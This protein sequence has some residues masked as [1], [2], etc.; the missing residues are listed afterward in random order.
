MLTKILTPPWLWVLL[1]WTRHLGG[2]APPYQFFNFTWQIINEAGDIANSSSTIA[3]TPDWGPLE[4]DLCKLALGGH[5]D[6]GVHDKFL[7]LAKAP[8]IP[9]DFSKEPGC[10]TRFSRR[11][12][13]LIPIYVCPGASHRDRSLAYKC[14]FSPDYFCAS[15]GCETTGDTYWN[16]SSSWDYIQVKRKGP[17][18]SIAARCTPHRW[19]NPLVIT[20]TEAGKRFDWASSRGLEWGLRLYRSG[21]DF[22]VTFKIKLLKTV[23]QFAVTAVGPNKA[24]HFLT[25]EQ[26]SHPSTH[27]QTPTNSFSVSAPPFQPTLPQGPPSSADLILSMV[28][29][30]IDALHAINDSL[31]EECWVCFSPKPP[32][33]EGVAAFGYPNLTNDTRH[34]GWHPVDDEGLTISQISGIGLCLRGPALRFPQPLQYT[35]NQTLI[36]NISFSYISAPEGFYFACSL[37]LTTYIVTNNFLIKDDYCVL[38]RLVPRLTIHES[39]NLLH[40]WE[41]G[42]IMPRY[43]REPISAI[44]LAVILGLG[45]TGAGTGIASL[46]TSQQQYAQLSLAVDRDIQELQ[47]GLENLKDSLVSLSEVVLQNRRGLDLLFLKEGGLCVAL[48]EEC[49]FYSDKTGLVQDSIQKVKNSLEERKR[50]REKQESWYQNWFSTSPWLSTLLP[51]LLGPLVGLLLLLSFGPWA[52]KKLTSFIK[53]QIDETTKD[54]IAVHYH[55]LNTRGSMEDLRA[56]ETEQPAAALQF[57][58]LATHPKPFRSWDPWRRIFG[59]QHL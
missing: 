28:N 19:C 58:T 29:A 31:Y 45:A 50:N 7:P 18:Q 9:F 46:I 54:Y 1:I 36:V 48:K 53:T 51:S 4:V 33:Y 41:Q 15:W 3:A 21:R 52:F 2:A 27:K 44:T 11:V 23:P 49:C 16:P 42:A 8:E 37:G 35:C 14:G 43:K 32:F 5:S 22:G 25:R 56:P 12:L 17:K 34:L 55:R 38:V 59:R 13:A 26:L 57:S 20:F 6:W 40:F 30:S 39:E 10:T 47:K 24:L